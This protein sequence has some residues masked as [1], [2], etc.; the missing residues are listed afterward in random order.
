MYSM[1]SGFGGLVDVM[2]MASVRQGKVEATE[3][4]WK[5]RYLIIDF[6]AKVY[7]V[8]WEHNDNY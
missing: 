7:V 4:M 1:M 2:L 5:W 3:L 8:Y 6:G